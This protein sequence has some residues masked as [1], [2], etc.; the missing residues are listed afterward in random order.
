VP[1]GDAGALADAIVRIAP[2]TTDS[3]TRRGR[4]ALQPPADT[5]RVAEIFREAAEGGH[6][7][8]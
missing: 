6:G 4:P 1:P 8:H 7:R 3:P 2:V 5:I